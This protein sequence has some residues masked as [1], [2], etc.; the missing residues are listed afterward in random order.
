MSID[1]ME[2][3]CD[4]FQK[5]HYGMMLLV[6]DG[7]FYVAFGEDGAIL[8]SVC[9]GAVVMP[10]DGCGPRSGVPHHNL[11]RHLQKLLLAGHRVAI[12]EPDTS[13]AP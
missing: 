2:K 5:E 11:D 4:K 13:K 9:D 3:I 8:Q 1:D 7:D 10:P 12:C 6:R